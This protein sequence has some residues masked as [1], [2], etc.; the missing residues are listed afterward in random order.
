MT[1]LTLDDWLDEHSEE[2]IAVRRH[3][4]ANPELSGAEHATTALLVE[5]LD[6]AGVRTRRLSSGTGLICDIGP[7]EGSG[8]GGRL[9]F[10]AD[11]DA[12]GMDDLKDVPYRSQVP[13]VCHACGHDVHTTILLGTALYFA[14]HADELPV[15]LRMIFQPAEEQV[16]GGALGVLADGGLDGVHAMVGLHCAPKL[17]VGSVALRAGSITSAADMAHIV[18][19][20]PGGHTA[21]PEETVDMVTLAGRV[22][23]DLPRRIGELVGDAEAVRFVFGSIHAGD[24]ANVIPTQARLGASVRTPHLDLWETLPAITEKA[25]E[26]VVGD[27]GADYD[28]DYTSGVPPVMNDEVLVEGVRRAA[29]AV[30]GEDRVIEAEQSWGGDDFAWYTRE[31]PGVY[32]RLGVHDP[33]AHDRHDLHIGRFDVD[34]RA[35]AYGIRLFVAI[36]RQAA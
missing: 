15:P 13:G 11:L 35:I 19:R 32:V 27:S 4:H 26:Q 12:L 14:H 31:V 33:S 7:P 23:A 1:P 9:A 28:L 24:A 16:P 2:L 6:A 30:C 3:L 5:R 17:D 8:F 10:R 21:R 25:L 20:G 36:A 29:V 34:E 18:L 22:V